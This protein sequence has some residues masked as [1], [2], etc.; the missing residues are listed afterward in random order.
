MIQTALSQLVEGK[1]L[2]RADAQ[3]TMASIM[4]GTASPTLIAAFLVALRMKGE[5]V[6]EITGFAEAMRAHMVPVSPQARPLVD[7]C[8]TGGDRMRTFNISTAAAFVAA[9]AGVAI[10]KHGN[11]AV[12]S[13]CGSA[14]VLE[15]LGIKI[16]MPAAQ[17][18][19]CIDQV[20]IGFMFA[21]AMHPA[22]KHAG[23]VRREM[24]IRTVFNML[25]PLAN[26]AQA[27]AQVLGVYSPAL[28]EF[29]AQVLKNL[30]ST[31]ALVVHG[32]EGLD[33]ISTVGPTR[34]SELKD[35][36]VNTY[37]LQ[38]EDVGLSRTSLEELRSGDCP[39]ENAKLL[40]EILE[41][42]DGPRRDI[43][44]LNAAAA[45]LCAGKSRDLCSGVS[46]AQQT[47]DSGQAL[48]KLDALRA[49]TE[50][51]SATVH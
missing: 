46:L 13:T 49:Y 26:P 17:V 31:R 5:T 44:I 30:G 40:V 28:T 16:D 8:G 14:D 35:G 42:K 2:D 50:Q 10:A 7:T 32:L 51:V 9:G 47:I 11:R 3:A 36:V 21:P 43:V 34:I 25:G 18:A 38:P 27:Q 41:G 48:Q 1:H 29:H 6:E 20:G 23:P 33:E 19:D 24:A 39:Q 12:S 45:L 22:M 37:E 15:A 4:E